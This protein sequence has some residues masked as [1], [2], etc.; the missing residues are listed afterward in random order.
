MFQTVNSQFRIK[1]CWIATHAGIEGNESS[2]VALKPP[3]GARF[4]KKLKLHTLI[5]NATSKRLL[6]KTI[7]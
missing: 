6:K 2:I 5:S 7:S 4:L 3:L 1:L